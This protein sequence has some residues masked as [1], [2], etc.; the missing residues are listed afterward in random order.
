MCEIIGA[1][2]KGNDWVLRLR[3]RGSPV[4]LGEV[5]KI[6]R[7]RVVDA[8]YNGCDSFE[9]CG[10]VT[11]PCRVGDGVRVLWEFPVL[12]FTL[13]GIGAILSGVSL[14]FA[15]LKSIDDRNRVRTNTG[16]TSNV[17]LIPAEL[18]DD[19]VDVHVS[20]K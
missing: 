14:C 5:A 8:V 11:L 6:R 7:N 4:V 1:K 20:R 3:R 13:L 16:T 2:A 12:P 10:R 19:W 9:K 17:N 18:A 15:A